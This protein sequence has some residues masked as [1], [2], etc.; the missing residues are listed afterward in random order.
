MIRRLWAKQGGSPKPGP[1][2]KLCPQALALATVIA[3]FAVEAAN[4]QDAVKFLMSICCVLLLASL[5]DVAGDSTTQPRSLLG[6]VLILG[7]CLTVPGFLYDLLG[8]GNAVQHALRH[9]GQ[10][11]PRI[12]APALSSLI[13][14]GNYPLP[15][16]YENGPPLVEVI[17]EGIHLLRAQTAASDRVLTLGFVNP[18]PA[19]LRRPSPRGS[20]VWLAVDYN[21]AKGLFPP[22]RT[23]FEEADA[24]MIPR[25][26][27]DAK[28]TTDALVA[29]YHSTL[30][31][32][33]ALKA[34]SPFWIL[35]TR[36]V[37]TR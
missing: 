5:P 22:S 13:F 7:L 26:D 23:L 24:V 10:S 6:A 8:F 15:Y 33:Y 19:C 37:R 30:E 11:V 17:N 4:Q 27:S 28:S 35:Y 9:S 3:E 32:N 12:D 34:E 1:Y 16:K 36:N 14:E 31:A 20:W 25:F 18:F 2:Y 21:V 29:E